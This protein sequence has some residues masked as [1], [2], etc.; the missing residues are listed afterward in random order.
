MK[1]Y[2]SI[3][4]LAI[5]LAL[6]I[7]AIFKEQHAVYSLNDE[8]AVDMSGYDFTETATF[9]GLMLNKQNGKVYDTYSLTP[10]FLQ[11]KDCPT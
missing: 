1:K 8:K 2:L 4:L 7:F 9:D 10:E 5:V 11:E 3:L 6:L